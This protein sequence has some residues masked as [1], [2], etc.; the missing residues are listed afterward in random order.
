MSSPSGRAWFL[1]FVLLAFHSASSR[2]DQNLSTQIAQTGAASLKKIEDSAAHWTVTL[3]LPNNATKYAIK[4]IKDSTRTRY[5]GLVT[6]HD[7]KPVP[8]F[9][10]IS[11]TNRWFVMEGDRNVKCRP[12]EHYFQVAIAELLMEAAELRFVTDPA[13][14]ANARATGT[15]AASIVFRESLSNVEQQRVSEAKQAIDTKEPQ[16]DAN[17]EAE[18]RYRSQLFA[19]L[20]QTGTSFGINT[21]AGFLDHFETQRYTVEVGDFRWL[22]QSGGEMV[23]YPAVKFVDQTQ[24]YAKSDWNRCVLVSH[25]SA[26]QAQMPIN[27]RLGVLQL[28]RDIITRVPLPVIG[29]LWGC[30]LADRSNVLAVY[31]D[32]I[33]QSGLAIVNLESGSQQPAPLD[34][35]G[36]LIGM[37]ILSPNKKTIA[38]LGIPASATSAIDFQMLTIDLQSFKATPIGNPGRLGAPYA[39]LPDGSGIVLKRFLPSALNE[40]EP[41]KICLLRLDGTMTDL[42][43]GDDPLV[44]PHLKSILFEGEHDEW[45]LCNLNGSNL[46][47]FADGMKG[48]GSPAVSP[49][50]KEML[51]VRFT[52]GE[53]P[54]LYQFPFQSPQGKPA[55][56]AIGFT[57]IPTW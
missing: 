23:K 18:R 13:V 29:T 17:A 46:V 43:D 1:L 35:E 40:I 49:D 36:K 25:D 52:Q 5:T 15:N 27:P 51:W 20:L 7:A 10:V 39:W 30:F 2:A 45:F 16:S 21:N 31:Q 33:G 26:A 32:L 55:T 41:R 44:I 6:L 3:T 11:E 56:K 28:N 4:V 24:P 14:L 54:H 42:F 47:K 19:R 50:G 22:P 37:P 9:S 8:F 48:W 53:L 12:W 57:S 34:Y 38:I